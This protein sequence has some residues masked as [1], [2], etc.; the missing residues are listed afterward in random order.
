MN[1][2]E[3][4]RRWTQLYGKMS[5]SIDQLRRQISNLPGALPWKARA[6]GCLYRLLTSTFSGALL[7]TRDARVIEDLSFI[8]R[9]APCPEVH[10]A[11][12][13]LACCLCPCEPWT[14]DF[15]AH[16][17]DSADPMLYMAHCYTRTLNIKVQVSW[18]TARSALLNSDMP[19]PTGTVQLISPAGFTII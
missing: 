3:D 10:L 15:S 6:N 2:S 13:A 9:A 8:T 19:I 4:G 7:V 5:T 17:M 18:T 16:H 1:R 12:S 11:T 14:T